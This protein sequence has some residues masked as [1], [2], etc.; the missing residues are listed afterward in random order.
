M[1]QHSEPERGLSFAY[2]GLLFIEGMFLVLNYFR[3]I[4]DRWH[5]A[6][7]CRTIRHSKAGL[8]LAEQSAYKY[9]RSVEG[10]T[11][12]SHNSLSLGENIRHDSA[13]AKLIAFM[14]CSKKGNG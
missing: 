5:S 14:G 6:T 2:R 13:K 4:N 10:G 12:L 8:P 3:G 1:L 11:V 7:P 9:W